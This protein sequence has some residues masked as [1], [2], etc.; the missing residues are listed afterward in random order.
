MLVIL[1]T[2]GL[3]AGAS[4][5]LSIRY[6]QIITQLSLMLLPTA[7][8]V[9]YLAN[10]E[11][12]AISLMFVVYYVFL[13][14]VVRRHHSEYWTSLNAS[15][16]IRLHSLELENSNRELESYS[17]SIAHDLRA[18]LRSI[19]SF[20]QILLSES[21]NLNEEEKQTLTRVVNASKFMAQLIDDILNLSRITRVK[22][23]KNR[24]DLS[25]L[26]N[27]YIKQ[28][29]ASDPDHDARCKIKPNMVT[30]GDSHLLY[31]ALQNL[32]DNSWKFT[33]N[34][35]KTPEIEIGSELKKDKLTY[36]IKD[37]GVGFDQ[38]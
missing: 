27:A 7:F 26:A 32:I 9:L 23:E 15:E 31:V 20:T 13:L 1:A 19:V 10:R 35:N 4:S 30:E 36:Y 12:V 38:E 14:V 8:M 16:Q 33:H 25:L 29:Q 6:Y 5:T 18:P 17:Y 37:N 22:L 2:A 3:A 21:K 34:T 11:S 24:V 28:L